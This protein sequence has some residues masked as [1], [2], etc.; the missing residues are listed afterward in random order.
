VFRRLG[1]NGGKVAAGTIL[2]DDVEDAC[3]AV[4]VPIVVAHDVVVVEIF[5]DVDLGDDLLAVAF[6]HALEI[7]L[8]SREDLR[9]EMGSNDESRC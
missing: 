4:D 3:I 9:R 2:H 8:F 1:Y 6:G 7:E 5:E